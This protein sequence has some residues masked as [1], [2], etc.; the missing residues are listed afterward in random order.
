MR[1]RLDTLTI[2]TSGM[3][4]NLMNILI[5]LLE[6]PMMFHFVLLKL[7]LSEVQIFQAVLQELVIKSMAMDL[8][9][10]IV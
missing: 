3:D 7:K 8:R 2:L 10:S 1:K 9:S 5:N 4:D 6:L